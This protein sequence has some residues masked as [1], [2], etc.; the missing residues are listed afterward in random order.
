METL[1]LSQTVVTGSGL[2]S[3]TPLRRLITLKLSSSKLTDEGC[4]VIGRLTT[5]RTLRVDSGLDTSGR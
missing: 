4:A 3:L 5:L 1:D 2:A